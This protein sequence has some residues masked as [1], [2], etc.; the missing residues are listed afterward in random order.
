MLD[1]EVLDALRQSR[2][3]TIALAVGAPGSRA[4]AP[5]EGSLP[6][7]LVRWAQGRKR[8]FGT[9]DV[10]KALKITRAHASMVLTRST[11]AGHLTRVGRGA[12]TGR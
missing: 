7:K 10:M 1:E 9:M 5:R 8:P 11:A 2:S 4:K 3:I 6:A 12:Y